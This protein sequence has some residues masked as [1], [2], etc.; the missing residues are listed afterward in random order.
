MRA[1]IAAEPII[2][3]GRNRRVLTAELP[4][5]A[6]AISGP[7]VGHVSSLSFPVSNFS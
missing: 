4:R 2:R 3:L 5:G 1:L 7:V 6:G